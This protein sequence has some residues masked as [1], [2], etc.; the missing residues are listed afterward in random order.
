[1]LSYLESSKEALLRWSKFKGSDSEKE[2][3]DRKKELKLLQ[4]NECKGN[5]V[6]IK[7]LQKELERLLEQK[8]MKWRQR[9]KQ[10]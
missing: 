9:A 8:D 1:M 2:I 3:K 10:N 6:E 7:S 4:M 5:M